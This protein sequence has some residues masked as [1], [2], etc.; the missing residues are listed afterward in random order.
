M[1]GKSTFS[2]IY[3]TEKE[4]GFLHSKAMKHGYTYKI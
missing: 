4:L 3:T 2:C 1:Q